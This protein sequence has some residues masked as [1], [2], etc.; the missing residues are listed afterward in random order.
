VYFPYSRYAVALSLLLAFGIL[1]AFG[2]RSAFWLLVG[3]GLLWI[4]VS[5][6]LNASFARFGPPVLKKWKPRRRTFFEWL[7]ER[8]QIRAPKVEGEEKKDD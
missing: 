8:D 2:V 6:L 5:L 4:P 1:F 7:Y 3:T